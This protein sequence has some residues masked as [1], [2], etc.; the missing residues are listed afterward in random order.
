M[1]IDGNNRITGPRNGGASRSRGAGESFTLDFGDGAA[2][3]RST[4]PSADVAGLDAMLALQSVEDPLSRRRR[5]VRRGRRLLDALDEIKI[6]LL[7]GRSLTADLLRLASLSSDGIDDVDD[8]GL[9]DVLAEID[10]RAAV[11]L[12]KLERK[13]S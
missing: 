4:R 10:L 9:K 11:E 2:E 5:A 7:E 13:R 1:R 12:A 8:P 6:G 3:T